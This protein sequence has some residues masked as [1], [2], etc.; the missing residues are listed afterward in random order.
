MICLRSGK[1]EIRDR[2]HQRFMH[3]FYAHGS[4]KHKNDSQVINHFTNLGSTSVNAERKQVG[5][6]ESRLFL[7]FLQETII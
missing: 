3:S 2:F 1:K 6:I 4:Q 7:L 5:E